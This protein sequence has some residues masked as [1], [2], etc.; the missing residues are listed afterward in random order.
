M[1]IIKNVLIKY[2]KP[3]KLI[4]NKDNSIIFI[5]NFCLFYDI[6]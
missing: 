1:K 2:K 3:N 6:F 4:M 5:K